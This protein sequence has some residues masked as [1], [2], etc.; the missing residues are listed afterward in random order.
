[1]SSC[2]NLT[3]DGRSARLCRTRE[4]SRGNEPLPST[5]K[6]LELHRRH[7]LA[8]G[9]QQQKKGVNEHEE[10]KTT[11][12][13]SVCESLQSDKWEVAPPHGPEG[14]YAAHEQRGAE[15]DCS[16]AVD[17]WKSA[18][19]EFDSSPPKYSTDDAF[20]K[21]VKNLS[22]VALF[23]PKANAK[24]DCAYITCPITTTSAGDQQSG[25]GDN[26][27]SSSS[28]E[29]PLKPPT[30][31]DEDNKVPGSPQEPT[32][33]PS[34]PEMGETGDAPPPALEGESQDGRVPDQSQEDEE[35]LQAES[36][37]HRWTVA[38]DAE[39]N[40]D[41]GTHVLVCMTKPS[42]LEVNSAPFT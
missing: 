21:S 29:S 40:P 1:M 14:P 38:R 37:P 35:S 24:V 25:G 13:E 11:F 31:G 33:K 6:I 30:Q 39:Q 7:H 18:I 12:A 26:T 42:A 3:D 15:A 9:G 16:A 32:A 8:P 4:L 5:G 19:V 41:G 10:V 17:H 22:F 23:N 2:L 28:K 20:Y 34:V 27:S 36:P